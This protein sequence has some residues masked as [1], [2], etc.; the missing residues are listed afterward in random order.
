MPSS[1]AA[2][3]TKPLSRLPVNAAGRSA[4]SWRRSKAERGNTLLLTRELEKRTGLES[5]VTIL[6]HVQRGGTPSP[7]DRLLA[8]RL[9]TQAANFIAAGERNIMVGIHG[10]YVRAVPLGEV[11][12]L[13]K[14]VP[15]DHTWLRSA[16]DLEICLGGVTPQK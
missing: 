4:P 6:G 12:G 7:K 11:A 5:R 13:R 16:R 2:K 10:D 1:T 3:A 14:N 8:T 15:Q 9:G